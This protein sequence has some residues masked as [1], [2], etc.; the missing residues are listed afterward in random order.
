MTYD[1]EA[2]GQRIAELEATVKALVEA[3]KRCEKIVERNLYHQHEK[4]ADVPL[5][6]RKALALVGGVS[7]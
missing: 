5:I 4:I 7:S 2:D 1:F 3:L 6:A